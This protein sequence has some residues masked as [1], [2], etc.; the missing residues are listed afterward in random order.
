MFV[1]NNNA[2]SAVAMKNRTVRGNELD[3]VRDITFNKRG[4][5]ELSRTQTKSLPYIQALPS[6]SWKFA[7]GFVPWCDCS[8][9]DFRD[10]A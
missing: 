1:I 2:I 8:R 6:D 3:V 10:F 7:G 4:G 9:T 5:S